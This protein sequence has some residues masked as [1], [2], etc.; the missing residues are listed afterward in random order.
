MRAT[1]V[2]AQPET[3]EVFGRLTVLEYVG[4]RGDKQLVRAVCDCGTEV[5]RQRN[6]LMSGRTTSCGC[7]RR[8][9]TARMNAERTRAPRNDPPGYTTA[10]NHVRKVRGPATQYACGCGRQAH[11]WSFC[12]CVDPEDELIDSVGLPYSLNPDHYSAMCRSC[13]AR[14]AWERRNSA[15]TPTRR[16]RNVNR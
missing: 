7:V 1:A 14:A 15:T 6:N 5:I 13:A 8:E 2:T 9:V 11:D 4:Y 12:H 16:N 10:R 3:R